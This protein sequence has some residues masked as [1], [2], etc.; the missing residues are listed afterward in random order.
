MLLGNSV[1]VMKNCAPVSH[2]DPNLAAIDVLL[3]RWAR[4]LQAGKSPMSGSMTCSYDERVAKAHDGYR[5]PEAEFLDKTIAELPAGMRQ[6]IMLSYYHELSQRSAAE[7]AELSRRQFDSVLTNAMR[8]C[9]DRVK[10]AMGIGGHLTTSQF[11][12]W[13]VMHRAK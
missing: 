9:A 4:W 11:R 3:Q 7:Q 6:S 10:R 1:S 5:D 13:V 8:C 2:I 12:T